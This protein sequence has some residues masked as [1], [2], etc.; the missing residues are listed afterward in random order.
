MNAR[1]FRPCLLMLAS[2]LSGCNETRPPLAPAAVVTTTQTT[3]PARD[4]VIRAQLERICPIPVTPAQLDKM[5]AY[6]RVHPDAAPVVGPF[7]TVDE[8]ARLCRGI[9]LGGPSS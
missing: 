6:I 7:I 4:L 8:G 9:P 5:A 3:Q 2:L 1:N